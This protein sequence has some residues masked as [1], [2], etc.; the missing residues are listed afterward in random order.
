MFYM[1]RSYTNTNPFLH[2]LSFGLPSRILTGIGL[3]GHWRLFVL[4]PFLYI[5]VPGYVC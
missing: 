4:V 2:S 5:F 1:R 3:S